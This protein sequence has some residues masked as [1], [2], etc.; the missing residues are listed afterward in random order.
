MGAGGRGQ[1]VVGNGAQKLAFEWQRNRTCP[2]APAVAHSA[3][4][5]NNWY[6]AVP[7]LEE[8]VARHRADFEGDANGTST[9]A[10][11]ESTKALAHK[12]RETMVRKWKG[13]H[14]Q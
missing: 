6:V 7:G 10:R 5:S 1:R 12:E 11:G 8:D 9:S 4:P 3:F 13:A 2:D 14:A